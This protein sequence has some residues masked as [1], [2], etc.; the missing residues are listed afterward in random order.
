MPRRA[1][2]QGSLGGQRADVEE[3]YDASLG[4]DA[5]VRL[6]AGGAELVSVRFFSGF[7][8]EFEAAELQRGSEFVAR[9][10]DAG[11]K[12]AARISI[13]WCVPETRT[14]EEPDARH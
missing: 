10:H 12:A 9:A 13:G 4:R 1:K 6:K 3:T 5:L 11:L 2:L 8:M 14:K 7:G